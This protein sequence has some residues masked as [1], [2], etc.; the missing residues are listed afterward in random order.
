MKIAF[1]ITGLSTGGAE[2]MLLKLLSRIDHS[3]FEPIV[4]SLANRSEIAQQIESLGIP[5]YFIGMKPG[6]FSISGFLRLIRLLQKLKPD[7]IQGWMYHGNVVAQI[8][9]YFTAKRTP[10]LWNIRGTHTDLQAEKF[11]TALTIWL[12]ARLSTLPVKIINNSKTSALLHERKL[13]YSANKRVIIPNGFDTKVFCP[14][15][16]AYIQLRQELDLPADSLL[17]GLIGRYH[18]MKDHANF[19]QAA[20][21]LLTIYPNTHFVLAGAGVELSNPELLK[22]V[23]ELRLTKAVHLLGRR[24]D[25]PYITAGLDIASSSSYGEGFPN[26]VGE[27]MSCGVPCVVTDVGDSA[28]IVGN[29]GKVVPP[30]NPI[31]LADAWRE[32]IEMGTEGRHQLGEQARQRV[33]ENF[34]LDAIVRQYERLYKQIYNETRLKLC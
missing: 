31:T 2:M 9:A 17:I 16:T 3:C 25:L 14:S 34:S 7:I 24:D 26:V 1:I 18:P 23:N 12:G 8:V 32:L 13:G 5:V 28:W 21:H 6:R 20:A 19:L 29:T 10:V 15:T 22:L 11:S 33:I 30:R 4:I 27:A